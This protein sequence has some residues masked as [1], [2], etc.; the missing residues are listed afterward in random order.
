[1]WQNTSRGHLPL[2]CPRQHLKFAKFRSVKNKA[3]SKRLY[4][5]VMISCPFPLIPPHRA[6]VI[7]HS[8]C[9]LRSTA[10]R[11]QDWYRVAKI[12][13]NIELGKPA[14][15]KVRIFADSLPY[16]LQRL[17]F[18]MT[19]TIQRQ[20]RNVTLRLYSSPWRRSPASAASER[21]SSL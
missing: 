17:N 20:I 18:A 12:R 11:G 19:A 4:I 14:A 3:S 10:R 7:L 15:R 5:Y 9:S 8:R 21:N 6:D 13:Q 2:Q 16:W 1:M